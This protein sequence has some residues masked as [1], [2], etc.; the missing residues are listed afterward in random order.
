MALYEGDLK[1]GLIGLV[2]GTAMLFVVVF[3]IVLLTN[4]THAKH[5]APAGQPPAATTGAVADSAVGAAPATPAAAGAPGTPAGA[6][7]PPPA[8]APQGS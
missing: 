8:K 7:P 6:P 3:G 2:A 4:A 1:A 5:P